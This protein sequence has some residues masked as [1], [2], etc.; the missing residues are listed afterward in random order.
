MDGCRSHPEHVRVTS[1]IGTSIEADGEGRRRCGSYP[2]KSP[3]RSRA[4]PVRVLSSST[5]TKN[6][7]SLKRL[8]ELIAKRESGCPKARTPKASREASAAVFKATDEIAQMVVGS[9]EDEGEAEE[10]DVVVADGEVWRTALIAAKTYQST[11]GPLRVTRKLYRSIRNG[12]TRCFFE[13]RRG[14]IQGV[15]TQDLGHVVV[16]D[17]GATKIR[18]EPRS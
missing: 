6:K 4:A 7:P 11:R 15:C 16:K 1:L 18:D 10:P 12:P 9:I 14:V 3:P 5:T 17:D 13:E 8:F 2:R